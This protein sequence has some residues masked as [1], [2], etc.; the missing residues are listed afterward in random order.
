MPDT[1]AL[2]LPLGL[3]AAAGEAGLMGLIG[4]DAGYLARNTALVLLVPFLIAGLADMHRILR[5]RPQGGLWLALF[6]GA[7]I[8]LFGWAAVAVTV[9]GVVRQWMRSRRAQ[10]APDQEDSDG[11]HSA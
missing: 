11:S 7:F 4:G 9:W 2:R 8:A 3:A 10:P 6:Y 1:A 5:S